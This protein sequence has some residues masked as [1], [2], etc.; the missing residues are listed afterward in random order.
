MHRLNQLRRE[1]EEAT[2][3]LSFPLNIEERAQLTERRRA[4]LGEAQALAKTLNISG[5]HWFS[6]QE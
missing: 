6:A 3:G 1:Y 2:N 4:I 5:D